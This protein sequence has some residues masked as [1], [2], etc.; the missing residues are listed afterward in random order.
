MGPGVDRQEVGQWQTSCVVGRS[1][2]HV[3]GMY[4]LSGVRERTSERE[5]LAY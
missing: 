2:D 4:V 1:S 3:L 5:K